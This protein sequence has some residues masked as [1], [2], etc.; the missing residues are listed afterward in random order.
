MSIQIYYTVYF[1]LILKKKIFVRTEG[2]KIGEIRSLERKRRF[3]P[4]LSFDRVA[5]TIV[6]SIAMRESISR[7]KREKELVVRE[8]TTL[9]VGTHK[10]PFH[11]RWLHTHT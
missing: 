10:S 5:S 9:I 11:A 6:R 2:R 1:Y 8:R 4:C 3:V 7:E